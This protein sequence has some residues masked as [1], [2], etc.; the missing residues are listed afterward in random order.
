MMSKTLL[1]GVTAAL[2]ATVVGC[3]GAPTA[4]Q[5]AP[6]TSDRHVLDIAPAETFVAIF[7]TLPHRIDDPDPQHLLMAIDGTKVMKSNPPAAAPQPAAGGMGDPYG[8]Y[9]YNPFGRMGY[10]TGYSLQAL[11]SWPNL[12][13][14]FGE[15]GFSGDFKNFDTYKYYRHGNF[16]FPYFHHFR[17]SHPFAKDH[18]FPYFYNASGTFYP[19][20]YKY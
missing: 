19:Y 3:A 7:K 16:Y 17:H 20:V 14:T 4:S 11:P 12:P 9:G 10:G 13:S 2:A 8:M 5:T 1:M 15:R 18:Y 6:V